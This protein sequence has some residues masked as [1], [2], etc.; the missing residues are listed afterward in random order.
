M[1][2]KLTTA[3]CGQTLGFALALAEEIVASSTAA[4]VLE[5]F[6]LR[7]FWVVLETL[8]SQECAETRSACG[9]GLTANLFC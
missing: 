6:T 9:H 2:K 4:K 3:H 5:R 1:M 8:G 7:L